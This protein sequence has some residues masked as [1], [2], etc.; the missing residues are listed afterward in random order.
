MLAYGRGK[1]GVNV[2]VGLAE[3]WVGS[4][5]EMI[6]IQKNL[7][8]Q[9]TFEAIVSFGEAVVATG[10]PAISVWQTVL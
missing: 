7:G 5:P 8:K 10:L 9:A 6:M 3:G 4:F 1:W 2:N